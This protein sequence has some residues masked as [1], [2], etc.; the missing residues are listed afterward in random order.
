MS[1]YPTPRGHTGLDTR[2][3]ERRSTPERR[4]PAVSTSPD[5]AGRH[6]E[7]RRAAQHYGDQA[8]IAGYESDL[9]T[10]RERIALLEQAIHW[11]LQD[12]A[13]NEAK[14]AQGTSVEHARAVLARTGSKP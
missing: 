1:G 5:Q 9:T 10:L 7:R 6:G 14:W 4:S 12:V 3:T 13:P 11:L 2:Q 8:Q